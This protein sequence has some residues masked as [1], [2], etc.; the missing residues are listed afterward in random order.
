MR[1]AKDIMTK[2]IITASPNEK[3]S[4]IVSKMEKYGIKEIPIVNKGKFVGMV[5]YYDILDYVR[6][7]PNEKASTLMIKPPSATPNTSIN[8][9][10]EL[11]VKTGVEAIPILEEDKLVGL[12]SDYD[13]LKSMV[14]KQ[15][16]K[17][18]KVREVM[19]ESVKLLK[20]NDPVSLA[21]RIMR[22]KRLEKLP[23]VDENGKLI[24]VI[25]SMDIL[26]KFYKQPIKIGRKDK[27]GKEASIL[28]I[29]VKSL[30]RTNIP[31][32][33]PEDRVSYALKKLF[34]Y[35]LKGVPVVDDIGRVIGLFERWKVLDKLIVRKFK[36][37]VWL[38][39]SGF[40]L[41]VETIEILKEYL[42]S[43]IRRMKI[44]CPELQSIDV[45]IKKMHGATPEKWNY[46][47]HVH[48]RKK[49]GKGEV[50]TNKEAWYGYNLM[51]TLQDAFDRLINILEKK[52][53][54]KK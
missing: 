29:P 10:I 36:E 30:M 16:L 40:P 53:K 33:H 48:L 9:I 34:E 1:L 43:D 17:R 52:C 6:I 11:M 18:I 27:P 20:E 22:H 44:L 45:H 25:T 47:V 4:K 19:E 42:S 32:I 46:E 3:I 26:T 50:V 38:N 23:I 31:E 5:T 12:I 35:N 24:G 2:K 13:I 39:F 41:S 8:D 21:R 49:A 7:D 28:M 37:G 15:K 54:K 14:N 51:F